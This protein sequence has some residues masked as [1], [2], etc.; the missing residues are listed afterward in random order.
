MSLKVLHGLVSFYLSRQH[1]FL[2]QY[3]PALYSV[4][5]GNNATTPP[6]ALHS[7]TRIYFALKHLSPSHMLNS[8]KTETLVHYKYLL[9]ERLNEWCSPCVECFFSP[10]LTSI[11]YQFLL[12]ITSIIPPPQSFPDDPHSACSLGYAHPL[13][14]SSL[15]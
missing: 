14:G 5:T 3:H 2:T 8:V 15:F 6:D 7:P 12:C 13:F 4:V 1:S 11:Y 9:N 10:I